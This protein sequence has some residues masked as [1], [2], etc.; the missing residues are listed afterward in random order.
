MAVGEVRGVD[1]GK[2][3]GD[4][5][6]VE[7]GEQPLD[8]ADEALGLAGA[9]VHVLSASRARRVLS[10]VARRGFRTPYGLCAQQLL[11]TYSPLG[12]V[13]FLKSGDIDSSFF[14]EGMGGRSG[15]AVF[16][17]DTPGGAGELL[18]RVSLGGVDSFDQHGEAARRG[19]AVHCVTSSREGVRG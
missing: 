1:S 7:Q 15:L 11:E 9:P 16:E 10:G 13:N 3:D 6:V 14:R 4:D 19:V 8:R 18:L 2:F 17:G 5:G 12:V